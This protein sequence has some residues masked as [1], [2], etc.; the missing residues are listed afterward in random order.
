MTFGPRDFDDFF[1]PCQMAGH[2]HGAGYDDM[3]VRPFRYL[4]GTLKNRFDKHHIFFVQGRLVAGM[5]IDALVHAGLPAVKRV[6]HE[7]TAQTELRIVL[8][9]VVQMQGTGTDHHHN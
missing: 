6:F 2:T 3:I 9:V 5:A 7:V 8:G 1:F 4:S